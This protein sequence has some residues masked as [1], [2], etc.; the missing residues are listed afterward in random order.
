M[1]KTNEPL[2]YAEHLV[3]H[4]V[5]SSSIPPFSYKQY[6]LS[7]TVGSASVGFLLFFFS[8]MIHTASLVHDDIL[9][10]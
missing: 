1:T 2:L 10:E 3:E 8:E 7:S 6:F 4:P 9:G 5:F